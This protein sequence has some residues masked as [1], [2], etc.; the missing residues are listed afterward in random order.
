MVQ[1]R[2]SSESQETLT[3]VDAYFAEQNPTTHSTLSSPRPPNGARKECEQE[4]SSGARKE[5]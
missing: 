1:E 5:C 3:S 2:R 4:T